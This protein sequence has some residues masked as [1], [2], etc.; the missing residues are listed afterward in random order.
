MRLFRWFTSQALTRNAI[1]VG[2]SSGI[3]AAL[4][5]CQAGQR[6]A[7]GLAERT[8]KWSK[9]QVLLERMRKTLLAS[10]GHGRVMRSIAK[11]HPTFGV[12]TSMPGSQLRRKAACAHS[13]RQEVA[14]SIMQ[15]TG[16][17]Q[18]VR[19]EAPRQSTT[20]TRT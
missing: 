20:V 4:A 11:L 12:S 1:I 13:I 16:D 14:A 10:G 2:A 15:I 3:G 5:R 8:N 6:Y 19:S 7:F 17:L 18:E 9:R